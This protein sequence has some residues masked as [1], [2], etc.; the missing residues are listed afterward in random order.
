MTAAREPLGRRPDLRI[1]PLVV[2]AGEPR[3][4]EAQADGVP[5]AV[6]GPSCESCPVFL[7]HW[8]HTLAAEGPL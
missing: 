8:E 4:A 5:C 1:D 2:L 3:C 6:L 7:E